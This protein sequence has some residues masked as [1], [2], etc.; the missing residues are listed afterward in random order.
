MRHAIISMAACGSTKHWTKPGATAEDFNRNSW[1]CAQQTATTERRAG[2][3]SGGGFYNERDTVSKDRYRA[4]LK[5]QGYQH[6]PGGAWEGL[7]D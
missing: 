5:A 7:R 3:G 6:V 1:A 4:C 2:F